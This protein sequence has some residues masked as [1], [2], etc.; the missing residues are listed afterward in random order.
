MPIASDVIIGPGVRIFQPDLV[1]LY[2]CS[3]GA[4]TKV[5][6]FVEIQKNASIG[7]R[8]KISSHSFICEGVTIEDECFIGHGVMF[9]ND[10][11]P[12]AVNEDGSQQTEA[13]W[14]VV[15]T[16]VK[17]RA[18]IGSNATILAGITIGEGALVGA[19]AVV[20]HD[21]PSFAIVAGVP[22]RVIADVRNHG[23]QSQGKA[24]D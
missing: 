21:V 3:I 19:G 18:S 5:G 17:K 1:N 16:V 13:D 11:H 4:D 6:A 9:T 2:G 20:T 7:E 8:C 24:N 22:A 23:S 10:V 15:K 12:R 14:K